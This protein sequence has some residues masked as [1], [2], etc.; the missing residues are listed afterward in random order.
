MVGLLPLMI[1][2]ITASLSSQIVQQ[3]V[4]VRKFCVRSG[5]TSF[6]F[7]DVSHTLN[8]MHRVSSCLWMMVMMS[9][10]LQ[11]PKPQV[12]SGDAF[13]SYDL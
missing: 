4:L 8:A 2:F 6:G 9:A 13:H 3:S 7:W 12:Q 5:P 10:K 11:Y 1:I